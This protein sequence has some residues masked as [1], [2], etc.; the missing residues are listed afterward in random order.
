[1]NLS[2]RFLVAASML[3]G[4][5]LLAANGSESHIDA[6]GWTGI[7]QRDEIRPAFEFKKNGGP[8]HKGSLNIRADKR[9]G[10]DGH[11]TKKF[12]VQGGQYY[13]F[14]A[15]RHLENVASP[16]RSALVRI[17]WRDALGRPVHH[18]EPGAKSYAPGKPPVAEPEYPP[19]RETDSKGWTEVSDVYQAPSKATQAIVELYQQEQQEMAASET[20]KFGRSKGAKEYLRKAGKL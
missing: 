4:N 15:L 6:D 5:S 11:W 9:E 19:D 17:L 13:S 16:R 2:I 7:A 3:V 8:D 18:D 1:M 20:R 14:R 10:L 12:S